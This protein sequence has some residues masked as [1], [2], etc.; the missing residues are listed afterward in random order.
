MSPLTQVEKNYVEAQMWSAM[1]LNQG[2]H[3]LTV[4]RWWKSRGDFFPQIKL[5]EVHVEQA[6]RMAPWWD[7]LWQQ[8]LGRQP[9]SMANFL[10]YIDP[11]AARTW[12]LKNKVH[13]AARLMAATYRDMAAKMDEP[14]DPE[15]EDDACI[16][17]LCD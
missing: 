7:D 4:R 17:A 2:P 3:L 5:D 8:Q 12:L 1:F 15:C 6:M 16:L 9:D 13:P 14:L 11:A 10:S